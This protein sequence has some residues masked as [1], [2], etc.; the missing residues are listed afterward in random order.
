ME[1]VGETE[2]GIVRGKFG[3]SVGRF[4]SDKLGK[5]AGSCRSDGRA[6]FPVP[7]ELVMAE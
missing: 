1:L 7:L 4:C 3:E 5:K 6:R 2:E